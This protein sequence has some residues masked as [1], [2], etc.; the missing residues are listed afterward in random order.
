MAEESLFKGPSEEEVFE[1]FRN[2]PMILSRYKAASIVVCGISNDPISGTNN[3]PIVYTFATYAQDLGSKW[4]PRPEIEREYESWLPYWQSRAYTDDI[5]ELRGVGER[6]GED[7]DEAQKMYQ[8][9][10]FDKEGWHEYQEFVEKMRAVPGEAFQEEVNPKWVIDFEKP[11]NVADIV[12]Q[13]P[14]YLKGKGTIVRQQTGKV[15]NP[16]LISSPSLA[17]CQMVQAIRNIIWTLDK[18]D[19]KSTSRHK[20]LHNVDGNSLHQAIYEKLRTARQMAKLLRQAQ[21]EGL[22]EGFIDY[23]V[24]VVNPQGIDSFFNS[25]PEALQAVNDLNI[26]LMQEVLEEQPM[27]AAASYSKSQIKTLIAAA[28]ILDEQV[29]ELA[30]LIDKV[31]AA[32]QVSKQESFRKADFVAAL[33]RVAD[34]LDV[35][36]HTEASALADQLLESLAA[37]SKAGRSQSM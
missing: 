32:P 10:H 2:Q 11:A 8:K 35:S 14:W 15:F 36:G 21:L 12:N 23:K 34:K 18:E 30:S 27:S 33:V 9:P 4:R 3:Y 1:S 7:F 25:I 20:P 17:L 13:A 24:M 19:I 6:E 26:R 28:D 31:V 22:E 5:T 16:D 37:S 29:P